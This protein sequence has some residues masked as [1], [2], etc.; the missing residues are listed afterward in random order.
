MWIAIIAIAIFLGVVT[1]NFFVGLICGAAPLLILAIKGTQKNQTEE[2]ANDERTKLYQKSLGELLVTSCRIA[3][4]HQKVLSKK[5]YAGS[6]EDEYGNQINDVWDEDFLY[7]LH[8]VI[9]PRLL[10]NSNWHTCLRAY[11]TNDKRI[12]MD[13]TMH[14]KKYIEESITSGVYSGP[15][16]L[17]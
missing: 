2:D 7:F 16:E 4:E 1:G 17:D 9:R 6:H 11:Q 5:Y 15:F 8:N 13:L 10:N 3:D 12:L 14:L